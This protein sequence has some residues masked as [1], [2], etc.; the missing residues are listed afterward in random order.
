VDQR[1][2]RGVVQLSRDLLP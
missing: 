2:R 1:K